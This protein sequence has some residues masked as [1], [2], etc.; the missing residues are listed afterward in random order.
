VRRC[1]GFFRFYV[2]ELLQIAEVKFMKR[3]L[4]ILFLFT[5]S[6]VIGCNEGTTGGP[7]VSD[8]KSKKSVLGRADDTFK[9]SVPIL[10]TSVQQGNEIEDVIIGINRAKNFDSDVALEFKNLPEG[11]SIRPDRPVI[12]HGDSDSKISILVDESAAKG[13]YKIEVKGHP[14]QGTDATITLRI[15]VT[16]KDSFSLN[17]PMLSTSLKQGESEVVSVKVNRDKTFIQDITLSLGG[18][19]TGVSM[20]PA[21]IVNRNGESKAEF[22]LVAAQDASLGRFAALLTGH[23]TSGIDASQELNFVVSKDE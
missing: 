7:G 14:T 8:A 5:L 20:E 19:P 17:L 21:S 23:P 12:K 11:V 6:P 3:F 15:A 1:V 16:A 4:K 9:L 13:E 10:Q 22:K 2:A 18:L